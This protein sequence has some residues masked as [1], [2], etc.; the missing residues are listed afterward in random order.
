M[1]STTSLLALVSILTPF[2][3]ADLHAAAICSNF[4]GGANVYNADATKKA[5]EAYKNRNTGN[6]QWDKCPDCTL[7][8]SSPDDL[9]HL[10][11]LWS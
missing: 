6:K 5:C 1:R 9:G 8:S 3:A 2:V 11:G 4:I 7:V 10:L